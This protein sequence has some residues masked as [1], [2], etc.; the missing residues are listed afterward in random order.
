MRNECNSAQAL[1][2]QVLTDMQSLGSQSIT[3]ES[4]SESAAQGFTQFALSVDH[5]KDT[6]DSWAPKVKTFTNPSAI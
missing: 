5:E 2:Q 4:G 6:F 3:L 1:G